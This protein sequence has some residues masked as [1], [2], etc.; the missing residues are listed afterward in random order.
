LFCWAIERPAS[1]TKTKNMHASA[2]FRADEI[3]L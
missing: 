3:R 1:R 2:T